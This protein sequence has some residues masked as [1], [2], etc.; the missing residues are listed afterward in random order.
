MLIRSRRAGTAHYAFSTRMA[1]KYFN[2]VAMNRA[3]K[4]YGWTAVIGGKEI[5]FDDLVR[6]ALQ[7]TKDEE[8]TVEFHMASG[9]GELDD[10][11]GN[12]YPRN[13]TGLGFAHRFKRVTITKGA[14][15]YEKQVPKTV[16]PRPEAAGIMQAIVPLIAAR[17]PWDEIGVKAGQL[18]VRARAGVDIRH[19]TGR[20]LDQLAHPD[21]P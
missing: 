19:D 5:D 6:D 8:K 4:A 21:M 9:R 16:E 20:T 13:E 18:G 17:R 12:L 11:D 15:T 7:G 1:R 10:L 14:N 2:R 3:L